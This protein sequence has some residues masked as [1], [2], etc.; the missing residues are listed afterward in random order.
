[1]N[2]NFTDFALRHFDKNFKGTRFENVNQEEFL[3]TLLNN[4]K[5]DN[6][7]LLD[8]YAPFCKLLFIPNFTSA[9]T[10]TVPITMNNYIYLE[11]D[12]KKRRE[13]EKAVLTRY[14][15]F[16]YALGHLIP[17]ATTL[18]VV[19][20]SKEQINIENQN[21]QFQEDY[22]IVS[23]NAQMVDYEEPM[24]PITMMRNALDKSEGGS[25][26][27]LDNDMYEKSVEFWSKNAIVG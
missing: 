20:Y 27:P 26:V 21:D 6:V 8:G 15:N 23:I 16:P 1:M 17:I 14:F 4:I 10:G 2:I 24:S 25:G 13:G 18:M 12:Y 22:G 19:L 3:D 7:K 11:T 9:K 5:S